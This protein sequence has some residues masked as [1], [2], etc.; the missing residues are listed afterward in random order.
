MMIPPIQM[1][2]MKSL[3]MCTNVGWKQEDK[4]RGD[5]KGIPIDQF[6]SLFNDLNL[7]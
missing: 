6:L 5:F 7:P 2:N 4:A 1:W 3:I